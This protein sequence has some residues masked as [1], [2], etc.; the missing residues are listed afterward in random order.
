MV[1]VEAAGLLFLP[2]RGLRLPMRGLAA[3]AFLGG[4]AA[5]SGSSSY[6]AYSSSAGRA[7][8]IA[9][10]VTRPNSNLK[11]NHHFSVCTK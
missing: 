2:A 11:I 6:S 3:A 8:Q 9:T 5:A 10:K 7:E 4:G 1:V